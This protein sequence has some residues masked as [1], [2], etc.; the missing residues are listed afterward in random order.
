MWSHVSEPPS[1]DHRTAF[2]AW[3]RS[4]KQQAGVGLAVY[5]LLHSQ[6]TVEKHWWGVFFTINGEMD[7]EAGHQPQ[8]KSRRTKQ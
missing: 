7:R 6:T 3:V 5:F 4:R 1:A 8:Q 2:Y